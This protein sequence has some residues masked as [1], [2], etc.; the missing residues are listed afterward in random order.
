MF[1][2]DISQFFSTADFAVEARWGT[3]KA[4]VHFEKPDGIIAGGDVI[5]SEY[6]IVYKA[7]DFP[8][9]KFDDM[10]VID[11]EGT[12]YVNEP[13]RIGDGKIMRATLR[14]V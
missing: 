10:L 6:A 8:G 13:T 2:E 7:G 9:L 12:F 4:N 11:C 3:K 14:K 5:S 1:K